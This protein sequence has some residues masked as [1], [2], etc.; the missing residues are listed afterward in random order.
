MTLLF[1]NETDF[2]I[3]SEL[4]E[5]VI[6]EA[7]I[8][9]GFSDNVEVSLTIVDN[10]EIKQLNQKFRNINRE[11]DVLSFPLIDFSIEKPD[12]N[13]LIYLGDIVISFEKAVS[14]ADEYG[15]SLERELGFL[16]AHSMLHLLGYDHIIKEEE[17]VMFKKQEEILQRLNLCR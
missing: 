8:Y 15:H 12:M 6:N 4:F 11:T 16:T 14:Q 5:R 7:L 3:N 9:E 13:E 2:E 1:S 10:S 17:A